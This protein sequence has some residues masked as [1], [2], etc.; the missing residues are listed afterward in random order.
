MLISALPMQAMAGTFPSL[1]INGSISRLEAL[2]LSR[3]GTLYLPL[4]EMLE[5]LG[6]SAD[7]GN[8]VWD[9]VQRSVTIHAS[10]H[11]LTLII[12]STSATADGTPVRLDAAP[13]IPASVG[14]TYV[15]AQLVRND[16]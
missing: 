11:D 13:F 16:R 1:V 5:R 4:R 10:L 14:R 2:I 3:N 12:C 9:A 7:D 6:L 8:L 15:D